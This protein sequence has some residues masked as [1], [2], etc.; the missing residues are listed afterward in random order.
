MK[1]NMILLLVFTLMFSVVNADSFDKYPVPESKNDRAGWL[2]YY[3][4]IDKRNH[5]AKASVE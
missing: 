2:K 4:Q 1:K 5:M 3:N